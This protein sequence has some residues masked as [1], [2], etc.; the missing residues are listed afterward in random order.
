MLKAKID[1]GLIKDDNACIVCSSYDVRLDTKS[2]YNTLMLRFD[3]I[4]NRN[5]RNSFSNVYAEQIHFFIEDLKQ[6]NKLYVCCDSGQSRSTAIAAAIYR[7]N[8]LNE[9]VIWKNPQYSPN[10]LVYEVLCKKLNLNNSKL[11]LKYKK[12]LNNKSLK[13]VIKKQRV[14]NS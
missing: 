14:K 1:E 2:I 13:N 10:I 6:I 11:R 4:T 7:Y 5:D 8:G 3:D 9:N 12:Y